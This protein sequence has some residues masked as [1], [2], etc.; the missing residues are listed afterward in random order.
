ML[1]FN[2]S[3]R[4][5]IYLESG[6]YTTTG[7]SSGYKRE[8]LGM[9]NQYVK[10]SINNSY[11]DHKCVPCS[12]THSLEVRQLKHTIIFLIPLLLFFGQVAYATNESSYKDGYL[13]GKGGYIDCI[14]YDNMCGTANDYCFNK[15]KSDIVTNTTACIQGFIDS[16]NQICHDTNFYNTM[17]KHDDCCSKVG[18]ECHIN[19]GSKEIWLPIT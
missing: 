1:R 13:N 6:Y 5:S 12:V 4:I 9:Y 14:G 19:M 3:N 10:N 15:Y 2:R 7:W 17:S 11:A 8:M 16:W 18:V